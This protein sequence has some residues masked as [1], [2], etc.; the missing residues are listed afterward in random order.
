MEE[1]PV[2]EIREC[3]GTYA[4]SHL[5]IQVSIDGEAASG[6][7]MPN[8]SN[9]IHR[10]VLMTYP[11][12]PCGRN[13]FYATGQAVIFYPPASHL[14]TK[15]VRVSQL[16]TTSYGDSFLCNGANIYRKLSDPPV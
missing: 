7:I 16:A 12:V 3:E 13:K 10:P 11:A 1:V 8:S 6:A 15:L 14:D 9:P 4:D 2:S 5:R